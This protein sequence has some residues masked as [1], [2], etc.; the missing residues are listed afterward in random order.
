MKMKAWKVVCIMSLLLLTMVFAGCSNEG[1]KYIGKWTGLEN[2]D[3]PLSSVH[4]VSIEKNGDNFIIKHKMSSFNQYG[5][6]LEWKDGKE[7][8][9]SSTLKDGKLSV[10]RDL[11]EN[12]YTY[13]EK[14][15]TLLFSSMGGIHLQ[16]DN[17]GKVLEEL[18]T[19]AEP[20]AKE[21]LEKNTPKSFSIVDPEVQKIL[22]KQQS[23]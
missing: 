15:D 7:Y 1:D 22:D 23:K 10:K 18:K 19:Q 3:N 5:K 20:L 17:D 13:I 14:D 8:Q 2:P 21:R 6:Q 12:T 16:R 4:Q 9:Y 11:G